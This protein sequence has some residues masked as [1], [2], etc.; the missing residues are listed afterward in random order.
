MSFTNFGSSLGTVFSI[1]GPP[2][3]PGPT[4]PT[5]P[6]G[7]AGPAPTGNPGNLVYLV[8][9]G[10]AGST[11]NVSYV[12]DGTLSVSNSVTTAGD[13]FGQWSVSVDCEF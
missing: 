7:P 2:G 5:G 13:A 11:S 8:S 6:G 3:P 1:G 10:V 12:A 4:G 9:S